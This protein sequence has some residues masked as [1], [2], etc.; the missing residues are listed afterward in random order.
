M[1]Y[2]PWFLVFFVGI[3]FASV[4]VSWSFFPLVSLHLHLFLFLHAFMGLF[5][6]RLWP[7]LSHVP[8]SSWFLSIPL[9]SFPFLVPFHSSWFPFSPLG[10]SSSLSRPLLPS[11]F[12]LRHP[13]FAP[14]HRADIN[15]KI[16]A[17]GNGTNTP[18]MNQ[19]L[20]PW[21]KARKGSRFGVVSESFD[22]FL[23]FRT[24]LHSSCCLSR[25]LDWHAVSYLLLGTALTQW[26]VLD[27]YDAVPG[28]VEAVIGLWRAD[29]RRYTH[30]YKCVG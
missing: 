3:G 18:G 24:S 20:L 30:T 29:G 9:G 14:P 19:K 13:F 1:V 27:F 6:L 4:L 26:T 25:A 12:L 16:F 22:F 2:G 28:L 5:L 10:S 15:A 7:L 17:I 11:S 8:V 23:Y 21:F